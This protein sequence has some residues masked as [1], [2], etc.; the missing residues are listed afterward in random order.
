MEN[1][2]NA[3]IN[4]IENFLRP[5]IESLEI[6]APT[7]PGRGRPRILPAMCLWA[8]VIVAVLRGWSCQLAIWRLLT[9]TG[10]WDYPRFPL[11]D[12]AI[13]KRLAK[14][15]P[16]EME[17]LFHLVSA[18]VAEHLAPYVQTHLA[19]FATAVVA[20]DLTTLDPV[21]RHLPILRALK[22]GDHQLLPGKLA[23]IFDLRCQQWTHVEHI[24]DPDQNEKVSARGL[25]QYIPTGALILFDLGFFSFAWF[26]ELTQL[27][28]WY[29]SRLR[30]KTSYTVAHVFY[31]EG[32]TFDGLIWLGAYRADRAARA[33][34]LVKFKVG[35][36]S[37]QYITNVLDPYQLSL[38]DLAVLYARRWDIE[39]AFKLI[40]RELNLHLLWSSKQE[41]VLI[42]VWAVLL[43]SQILHALQLEIAGRA[44][45]DPFDV[46]LPL[47][48]QYLSM[49]K[50]KD[51]VTFWVEHGKRAGFIRPSRRIRIK[52]PPIDLEAYHLPP[53][54]LELVRTPRYAG[55]T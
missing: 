40:K 22:N 11:S 48:V 20:I 43:I 36:L 39:M 7:A 47:L 17:K 18:A 26:D 32:E 46:S 34:R 29:L 33:V 27:G 50:D 19:P 53:S 9:N 44:E 21:L 10:L 13:Y 8:G 52:T 28:Y 16:A 35:Q 51:L 2:K 15:G 5:L 3:T 12:Q 6:P 1:E 42:Q 30:Q 41:V 45:V 31:Q 4:Q 24:K 38:H 37:Y 54:D 55:K 49:V 25:L 23:S 14:D